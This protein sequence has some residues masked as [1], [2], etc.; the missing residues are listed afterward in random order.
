M[1]IDMTQFHAVFFEE[2]FEGLAIMET[3]LLALDQGKAKVEDINTIFRAVHSMKGGSATFGFQE[4]TDFTHMMETLL[5]QMRSGQR[6][7]SKQGVNLLLASVD[8]LRDMLTA[9]REGNELE[10]ESIAVVKKNL[11]D[12]LATGDGELP[13]AAISSSPA[14]CDSQESAHTGWHIGFRPH[15]HM[16]KTGNDPLRMFRELS[17]LGELEVKVDTASL[18]DFPA[19]DPEE[20]FLS[21]ELNLKGNIKRE[22]IDE[23]FV[24]VDGD[25]DL[26]ITELET[27]TTTSTAETEESAL[28]SG[29]DRRGQ[30]DRRQ[31]DE[32]VQGRNRRVGEDRRTGDR[33]SKG[34]NDASIRVNIDKID[35]LINMV[36]E[37]V[38][39]QSMLGQFRE[40]IDASNI[41][42][43]RNGLAQLERNTRELQENVMQIRMHPISFSFKRFPR[44]V[45][46]LSSKMNKKIE[47]RISG[48]QTELDKTVLEKIGDPL[49]HLIRNSLDHGIEMPEQRKAAGK[50]ETGLLHL[51]AY[52]EGGN[53]VIEIIDDGAGLNTEKIRQKAIER[54]LVREDELMSDDEIHELIFRPGFSTA[55]EV[56][57][58]S[59]R[60]VG[61]DVVRRNII[62][63]GGV[64]EVESTAGAGS[65]FRIRL[66]LTLAIIDGQLVRVGRQTYIVPL[67]S[68]MESLQLSSSD[69]KSVAGKIELCRLRDD[70]IPIIRLH[71][72]FSIEPDNR[73]VENGLL[74][75]IE[76]EGRK[77]GLFVDALLA[78][79]QVVIK[80]LE[81][82]YRKVDGI[83]GAT[84]LGDGTVAMILDI[85]GLLNMS[86][87]EN[88][89]PPASSL[90]NTSASKAA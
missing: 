52:H 83:A 24:W 31:T 32:P 2:S 17:E 23:I 5:D 42:R 59:G 53:I 44:L 66:P 63:L 81:T 65:T 90:F 82:N 76:S 64:V 49:V 35:T 15:R 11:H 79:Q 9:T 19:Y 89:P 47:L 72:V 54:E 45:H 51:N 12:L 58:V 38:I 87:Q 50:S 77:A 57:D 71:E 70:Y 37:L 25:C 18:P 68:I 8:C 61:M 20:C 40:N 39:T 85:F 41:E 55:D 6:S 69:I 74:V 27:I 48:E 62:D 13:D 16:L 67:I 73:H 4:I 86:L 1:S 34:G 43:L 88:S 21:W 7:V 28:R 60:G 80:S 22:Q 29:S 46:D 78:Q 10:T 84:I 26:A 75:V 3:G 33:R 14:E 36:G 30:Q 56:S